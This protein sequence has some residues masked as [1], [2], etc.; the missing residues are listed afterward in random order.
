MESVMDGLIYFQT[1]FLESCPNNSPI[2]F[3]IDVLLNLST[4]SIKITANTR[5]TSR[6]I[7]SHRNP[8]YHLGGFY[9]RYFKI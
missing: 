3:C 1:E 7:R 6:L 8:K 4:A 9:D 5:L 2:S